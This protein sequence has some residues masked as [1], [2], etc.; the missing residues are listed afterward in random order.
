MLRF[1]RDFSIRVPLCHGP[2]V[3]VDPVMKVPEGF[4]FLSCWQRVFFHGG[5]GEGLFFQ[6]ELDDSI[7]PLDFLKD[8]QTLNHLAKH[9]VLSIELGL[10]G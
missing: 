9:C 3:V 5:S 4:D 7:T 6:S 10:G 8:V 1:C 2:S